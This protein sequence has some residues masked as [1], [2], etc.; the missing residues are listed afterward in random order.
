[1]YVVAIAEI[2]TKHHLRPTLESQDGGKRIPDYETSTN[3][4]KPDTWQANPVQKI[5]APPPPP[6]IKIPTSQVSLFAV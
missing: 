5:V 2:V 1:M 6:F 4:K 3:M